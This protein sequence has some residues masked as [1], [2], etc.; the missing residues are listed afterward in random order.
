MAVADTV[1]CIALRCLRGARFKR[2]QPA[3]V[4]VLNSPSANESLSSLALCVGRMMKK[5]PV[6]WC[7]QAVLQRIA[8]TDCNGDT[9][10]DMRLTSVRPLSPR[11]ALTRA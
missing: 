2:L 11:R 9:G 4:P 8:G 7:Y 6:V 3:T 1:V 10:G 5:D